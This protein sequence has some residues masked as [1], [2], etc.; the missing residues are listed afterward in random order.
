MM[1]CGGRRVKLI[2][3]L[4]STARF[5]R[6]EE[7]PVGVRYMKLPV[8]GHSG[9][10]TCTHGRPSISLPAAVRVIMACMFVAVPSDARVD[11]AI[12]LIKEVQTGPPT[13]PAL[14][15]RIET[16][17]RALSPLRAPNISASQRPRV[18]PQYF[19]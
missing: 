18:A 4:T 11:E 13:V 9:M 16:C 19:A 15:P 17:A 7:L 2:I 10:R 5:Y 3:D 6:P 8:Q 12:K 14:F 1:A